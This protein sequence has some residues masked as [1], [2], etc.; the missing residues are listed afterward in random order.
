MV[1]I[2]LASSSATVMLTLTVL[3]EGDPP[4]AQAIQ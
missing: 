3:Q 4:Q 2:I 1:S